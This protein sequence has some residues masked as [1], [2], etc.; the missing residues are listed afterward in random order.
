MMRSNGLQVYRSLDEIPAEAPPAAVSIGNFDG[1][2]AGHRRLLERVVTIGAAHAWLPSVLTFHPH[3]TRVVAPDRAPKLLST[4]EQRF[5]WMA[6]SGI[7]QV[8][9]LPFTHEVSRLTPEQFVRSVLVERLHA[10]AVVV[11]ENFRFGHR[12]AG[13]MAT[14][15]ELGRPHGFCTEVVP[16]V[17]VRGR[18]VSSSAV[19]SLIESGAVWLAWR[20]LGRPYAL[21]GEVVSGHGIGSKQT[22]PTLNLSTDAEVLPATGV[23]ITRTTELDSRRSWRSVTNIGYRPTFEGKDLTVETYVLETLQEPAPTRIRVEFL[24]RLREERRFESPEALKQQIL[25]DVRNAQS[26]FRRCELWVKKP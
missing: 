19:R 4:P 26:Y 16:G 17:S 23:Y 24:R 25:R 5:T 22:V 14:L 7:E 8:L 18:L 2:H 1:V 21:E 12:Q 6:E 20:L 15:T 10:R 3:P 9:L 13:D 11:G